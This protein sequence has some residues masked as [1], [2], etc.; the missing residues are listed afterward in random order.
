MRLI[1][2]VDENNIVFEYVDCS[3]E[4]RR[5]CNNLLKPKLQLSFVFKLLARR[6]CTGMINDPYA[7]YCAK[8][9]IDKYKF[10]SRPNRSALVLLTFVALSHN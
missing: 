3:F 5:F 7:T 8:F 1:D 10:I 9:S 6:Y 2:F 4:R